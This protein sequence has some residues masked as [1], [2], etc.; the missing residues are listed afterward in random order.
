M[1]PW[2]AWEGQWGQPEGSFL[3]TADHLP[4]NIDGARKGPRLR[5]VG[6]GKEGG[7]S[8]R[9]LPLRPE[10]WELELRRGS[11]CLGSLQAP[12]ICQAPSP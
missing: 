12:P 9:G 11:L 3:S 8:P 2:A 5:L 4:A 10:Q 6:I 1:S 7:V